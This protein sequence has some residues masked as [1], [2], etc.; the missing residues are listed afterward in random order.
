MSAGGVLLRKLPG[1]VKRHPLIARCRRDANCSAHRGATSFL[2]LTL[3]NTADQGKGIWALSVG[4]PQIGKTD[5]GSP[6]VI[7]GTCLL[8]RPFGLATRSL[9]S[10]RKRG[11]LNMDETC[12]AVTSANAERGRQLFCTVMPPPRCRIERIS[13]TYVS[14]NASLVIGA[15]S[16]CASIAHAS[17]AS[18]GQR[19]RRDESAVILA[20]ATLT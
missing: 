5:S 18:R 6:C 9:A 16:D 7:F 2:I 4:R 11:Q 19:C 15:V 17:L 1:Q 8:V 14:D 12:I 13:D 3:R 10:T 20:F